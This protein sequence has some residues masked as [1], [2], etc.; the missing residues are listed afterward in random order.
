MYRTFLYEI[1]R[2]RDFF[3]MADKW[4]N[5][6]VLLAVM[7]MLQRQFTVPQYS[8]SW[9][10]WALFRNK[11][12]HPCNNIVTSLHATKVESN[13]SYY[14]NSNLHAPLPAGSL[15]RTNFELPSVFRLRMRTNKMGVAVISRAFDHPRAHCMHCRQLDR[16]VTDRNLKRWECKWLV[17]STIT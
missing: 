8:S 2:Q 11:I 7:M 3:L 1:N 17:H 6:K 4:V 13:S 9:L 16:G 14:H 5:W 12:L 10:W 15:L